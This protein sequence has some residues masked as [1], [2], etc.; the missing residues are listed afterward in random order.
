[1]NSTRCFCALIVLLTCSQASAKGGSY[2]MEHRYN[3]Q[4]I[5]G[6][7]LEVRNSIL[8]RC[9]EPKALHPFAS[10]FDNSRRVVLHFEHFVCDGVFDRSYAHG[11]APER[12]QNEPTRNV[13]TANRQSWCGRWVLATSG[14][15]TN[16]G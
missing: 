12:G 16:G 2:H 14:Y 5:D 10:Y 1:M 15:V 6:L 7:P 11:C 3:P 9:A 13:G 8:H 4:H